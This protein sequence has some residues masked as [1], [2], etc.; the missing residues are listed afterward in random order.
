MAN[1]EE[2]IYPNI[3]LIIADDS[4]R[5]CHQEISRQG[6][7]TLGELV[8]RMIP[9]A[10]EQLSDTFY[11]TLKYKQGFDYT[12]FPEIDMGR[13]LLDEVPNA[14][15]VYV[16]VHLRGEETQMF[17]QHFT[18]RKQTELDLVSLFK[19][20][21]DEVKT[22]KEDTEKEKKERAK[23]RKDLEVKVA[24]ARKDLEA[25]AAKDREEFEEKLTQQE[26]HIE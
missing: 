23:D 12:T 8:E 13:P 14:E 16:L 10:I 2:I 17:Q 26:I 3:E 11:L 19:E 6:R 18:K 4:A 22:L 21:R 20:V 24:K 5:Y 9:M 7:G 25:K 15:K 1:L